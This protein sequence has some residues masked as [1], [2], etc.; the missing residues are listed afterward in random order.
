MNMRTLM[1]WYC[2]CTENILDL[3]LNENIFCIGFIRLYITWFLWFRKEGQRWTWRSP[4][5]PSKAPSSSQGTSARPGHWRNVSKLSSRLKKLSS[6]G[7]LQGQGPEG[8]GH[9]EGPEG[10]GHEEGP[11]GQGRRGLLHP[12]IIKF[13]SPLFVS[14]F[15]N[16][17]EK[18]NLSE[19][20]RIWKKK[21]VKLIIYSLFFHSPFVCFFTLLSYISEIK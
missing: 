1:N 3:F 18:L 11:G 13:R 16:I 21:A 4:W 7:G 10:Q 15:S 5:K 6:E 9:G 2:D 8:R 20:Y 12:T 14:P 17:C 19:H